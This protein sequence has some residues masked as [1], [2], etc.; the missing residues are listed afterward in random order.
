MKYKLSRELSIKKID[1]ETFILNRETS[2]IH[3]FNETGTC[4]WEQLQQNKPVIELPEFLVR[5][6]EVSYEEAEKDLHE[7]LNELKENNLIKITD[8]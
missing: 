2:K 3:S 7:F 8:T 6:F 4:I 5:K 1:T